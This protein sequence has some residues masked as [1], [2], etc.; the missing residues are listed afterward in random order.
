MDG[1]TLQDLQFAR[2]VEAASSRSQ[3]ARGR[4]L[5]ATLRE[6]PGPAAAKTELVLV[7]Q[8]AALLALPDH[9]TLDGVEDV[10]S[11]VESAARG[12]VLT[13][14]ELVACAR[15]LRRAH[16]AFSLLADLRLRAPE[17]A[18][19]F[20][21]V[22]D[23][24]AIAERIEE[25]FDEDNRIRD[26]ASPRL[27]ELRSR[28]V[29]LGRRV[30]ERIESMLRDP[31]VRE[32]LQDDYYTLREGRYVLPVRAEDHRFVPGIIHGTS[33]TGATHFVE[34][35]AIVDDN[36]QLKLV[37]DQIEVEEYAV[38][39]DRSGLIGRFAPET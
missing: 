24:L 12:G 6:L 30:K 2:I 17:L 25:T 15:L 23:H 9:P 5:L 1:R 36:N 3:T 21:N 38:L 13:A 29:H 11:Q 8:A 33:R 19:S 14:A 22:K 18:A 7:D 26:D 32:V 37:L 31:A 4:A 35:A 28:V 27:G 34:P 16:E 39:A 20:G 10:G